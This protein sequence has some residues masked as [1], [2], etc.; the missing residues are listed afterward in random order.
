ML[1]VEW[2]S[3]EEPAGDTDPGA[4]NSG[5]ASTIHGPSEAEVASMDDAEI[6]RSV[7][8]INEKSAIRSRSGGTESPLMITFTRSLRR[9]ADADASPIASLA[10]TPST[11][12][13]RCW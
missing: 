3:E 6:E 7:A 2:E 11:P 1:T 13:A 8:E 4:A 5:Y 10:T 12:K 9:A